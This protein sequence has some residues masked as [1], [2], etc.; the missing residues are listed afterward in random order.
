MQLN[1]TTTNTAAVK[2]RTR[3]VLRSKAIL[4]FKDTYFAAIQKLFFIFCKGR[5]TLVSYGFQ[6]IQEPHEEEL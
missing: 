6:G 3:K 4:R 2:L 5:K 1:R